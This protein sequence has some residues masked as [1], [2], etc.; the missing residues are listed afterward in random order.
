MEW[1]T[2]K[3]M[4]NY[5]KI[6]VFTYIVTGLLLFLL[7]FLMNK[8]DLVDNMINIGI[9]I[10]MILC[11]LIGG[12]LGGKVGKKKRWL[13]GLIVGVIYFLVLVTMSTIMNEGGKMTQS[14]FTTFMMCAGSSTLGAM[15]SKS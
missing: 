7:A 9:I 2:K 8:F 1:L 10:I 15:L 6:V 12:M 13:H 3:M 5:L 11:T 4:L 14:F